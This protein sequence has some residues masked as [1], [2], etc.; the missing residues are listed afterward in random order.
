MRR[1]SILVLALTLASCGAPE[2]PGAGGLAGDWELT[3]ATVDRSRLALV[4]GFPVTLAF[5]EERV[6]GTAACNSYFGTYTSDGETIVISDLGATEM[7]CSPAEVMDLESS[8][9]AALPRASRVTVGGDDLVLVGEDVELTFRRLPP[10]P[11]AELTETVWV[12]ESLVQGDTVSSVMGERATLELF[13][14]GSMLGSTGCRS[15]SGHY[16]VE[17]A[18]VRLTDFTANG[19]CDPD[20]EPQDDHVV[21]V[22]GDG[23]RA[24]VEGRTLTVTSM[25]EMG[26]VYRAQA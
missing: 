22:L 11:T 8:F 13:T 7:A 12:L 5:D 9:L 4:D 25:G 16:L 1:A 10:V 20:L 21:T 6:G 18:E 19:D 17:G 23:F 24:M 26:L 2:R 15:L 14:D 3:S